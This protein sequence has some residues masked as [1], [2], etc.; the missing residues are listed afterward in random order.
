MGIISLETLAI[1]NYDEESIQRMS[2]TATKSN[3]AWLWRTSPCQPRAN[4]P[5]I[6]IRGRMGVGIERLMHN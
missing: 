5:A 2:T 3:R 1:T 4:P 6:E